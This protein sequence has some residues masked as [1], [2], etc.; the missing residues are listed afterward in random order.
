MTTYDTVI[1]GAGPAGCSAAIALARKGYRVLLLDKARF[2]REK[3]CGEGVTAASAALL[4]ALG[5]MELLRQRPGN[6]REFNG[7]TIVSPGG[8]LL[9]G[10]IVQG[11]ALKE[12]SYIIQRR[13]L[14]EC[15]VSCAREYPAITF[16]DNTSV[17]DLLM[18][19]DRSLGVRTTAGDFYGRVIIATDGVYSPIASRLKLLNQVKIHQGFAM[20]AFFSGVEGLGDS[21][22]L[23]YDK[24][25][26]PGYG[27]L[28]P[29][30]SKR[31]N[32]G[33]FLLTRFTDQRNLRRMFERFITE[34]VHASAKLRRAVMEPGTLKSWPLPLGSFPGKRSQGNVLLAGDAGSFIDPVTGEGIYYALK[35]GSYAAEAAA[36]V[37]GENCETD[38]SGRYEQLWREDFAYRVYAIGYGFQPFMNNAWFVETFMRYTA[39]KQNRANLLA[40]VVAHNRPRRDLFRILNPFF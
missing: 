19:G 32:I 13:A 20:R 39:R 25:L 38:A 22:E 9:Q 29:F 35:S 31:A 33:V 6:L 24:P 18:E 27:W 11:G 17:S 8:T 5:V 2:P 21:I 7:V 12:R 14:D 30:G 40:D 10:R 1:S 23:C 37:L 4:E 36:R 3:V 34:S 28:F 26:L 15:L 16:L